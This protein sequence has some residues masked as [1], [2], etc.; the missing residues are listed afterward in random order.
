MSAWD[1]VKDDEVKNNQESRNS[2]GGQSGALNDEFSEDFNSNGDEDVVEVAEE[3]PKKKGLNPKVVA[4]I[5]GVITISFLGYFGYFAY[6][7]YAKPSPQARVIEKS[8]IVPLVDQTPLAKNSA[9]NSSFDDLDKP[10]SSE[11]PPN[12]PSGL[13]NVAPDVAASQVSSQPIEVIKTKEPTS[14]VVV[15]QVVDKQKEEALSKKVNDL[16]RRMISIEEGLV[17]LTD[18]VSQAQA[19]SSPVQSSPVV[20]KPVSQVK[21]YPVKKNA[22]DKE[23]KKEMEKP[24]ELKLQLRGVYPPRGE[25]RQAWILD[26]ATNVITV[27]TKGEKVQGMTVIQIGSDY[28]LTDRGIIR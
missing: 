11:P 3:K 19:K 5:L 12:Q 24:V 22:S 4:G 13:P 28:I 7:K 27:V 14:P 10:S 26:P 18:A 21:K 9:T 1:E 16:D 20:S 6:L 8:E 2:S 23:V 15:S 17:K 25:D